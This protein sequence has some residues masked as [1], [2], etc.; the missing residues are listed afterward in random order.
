MARYYLAWTLAA[1]GEHEDAIAQGTWLLEDARVLS[2][3]GRERWARTVL[4]YAYLLRGDLDAAEGEVLAFL[5]LGQPTPLEHAEAL[6]TLAAIRLAQG[7]VAEALAASQEALGRVEAGRARALRDPFIRLVHVDAL[8]ASGDRAAADAALTIAR[9]R[10]L[11][12]AS[13]IPDASLC[14]S[15]LEDVPENART[16]DLARERLGEVGGT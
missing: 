6:A 15:F 9:D 1:R 11:A 5:A 12:T 16:I 2:D 3:T 13:R 4:A 10:L 7:R 14:R 8:T